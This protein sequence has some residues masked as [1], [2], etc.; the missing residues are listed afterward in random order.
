MHISCFEVEMAEAPIGVF[1]IS[2]GIEHIDYFQN[3]APFFPH[4]WLVGI[5]LFELRNPLS[6]NVSKIFRNSLYFC[7]L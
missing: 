7:R 3:L 2:I 5:L 1:E 6:K 4:P